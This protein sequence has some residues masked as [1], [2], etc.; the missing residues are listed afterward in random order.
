[1]SYFIKT[2]ILENVVACYYFKVTRSCS[3]SV[4]VMSIAVGRPVLSVWLEAFWREVVF[5]F[6]F[7]LCIFCFVFISGVVLFFISKNEM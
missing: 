7:G 5:S 6:G 2:R 3:R 1:M 4:T